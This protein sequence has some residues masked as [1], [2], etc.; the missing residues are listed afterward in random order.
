MKCCK[1]KAFAQHHEEG[2]RSAR[3]KE[4]KSKG[5]M[6]TAH[7]LD[8]VRKISSTCTQCKMAKPG[9][10]AILC[11]TN[12]NFTSRAAIVRRVILG[13]TTQF[14]FYDRAADS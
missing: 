11:I 5:T 8:K 12:K 13:T 6:Q 14:V 10:L 1:V 4:M 2:T 7:R 9:S 3:T